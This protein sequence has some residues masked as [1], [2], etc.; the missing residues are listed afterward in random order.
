MAGG[1]PDRWLTVP[2]YGIRT[3]GPPAH[4]RRRVQPCN[5]GSHPAEPRPAE[6]GDR[7][8]PGGAQ[9]VHRRG[10]DRRGRR[11]LRPPDRPRRGT[12]VRGG[13]RARRDGDAPRRRRRPGRRLHP[14]D[15]REVGRTGA[16]QRLVPGVPR[17]ATVA[18]RT[19]PPH[20]R[21]AGA[22]GRLGVHPP[23]AG[24]RPPQPVGHGPVQARGQGGRGH[25]DGGR[26]R[27]RDR[28]RHG[29]AAGAY[30]RPPPPALH[31][32]GRPSG[33]RRADGP[34]VRHGRHRRRLRGGRSPARWSRRPRR[35]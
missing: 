28:R 14:P 16:L 29:R 19:R 35:S 8:L 3:T 18:L 32:G 23:H 11:L 20:R 1:G 33:G 27:D 34:V 30:R 31:Q 7:D 10:C 12:P 13:H 26:G 22:R 24:P 25:H 6:R 9:G 21:Q 17:R 4:R 2:T 15:R 5:R